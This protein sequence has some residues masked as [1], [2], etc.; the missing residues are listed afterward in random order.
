M[1]IDVDVSKARRLKLLVDF[2]ANANVGD[3][4]HFGDARLVK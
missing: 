3:R 1:D 2:G 4:L